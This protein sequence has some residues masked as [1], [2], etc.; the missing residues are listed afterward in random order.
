VAKTK[1][2]IEATKVTM[3]MLM[4]VHLQAEIDGLDER[5]RE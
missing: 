3:F 4:L 1:A 2:G 5:T